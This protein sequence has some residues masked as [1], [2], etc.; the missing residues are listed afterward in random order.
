MTERI[1]MKLI[2]LVCV[3]I[4]VS[5]IRYSY[6]YGQESNQVPVHLA[7]P[8][9]G[10]SSRS[11]FFLNSPGKFQL[12]CRVPQSETE[13]STV[14]RE[15]MPIPCDLDVA[16]KKPDGTERRMRVR[17]LKTGGF[18]YSAIMFHPQDPVSLEESGQYELIITAYGRV[19]LFAARGC[20][21]ELQRVGNSSTWLTFLV[22]K[23]AG[24]L[25]IGFALVPLMFDLRPYS[26][27]RK[28]VNSPSD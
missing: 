23:W 22:A 13:R 4:G 1:P 18:T 8:G 20:L 2:A 14:R 19:S 15:Y 28:L 5:L 25:V 3:A 27:K 12:I 26:F 10:L 21:V 17:Q 16:L 11:P 9:D 7:F 24:F 6:V